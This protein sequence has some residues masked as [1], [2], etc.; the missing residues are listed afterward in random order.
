MLV[1]LKEYAQIVGVSYSSARHAVSRG[2]LIPECKQGRFWMVDDKTPWPGRKDNDFPGKSYTRIYRIWQGMKKRCYNPNFVS[3]NRY[4]GRGITVCEEWRNSS[5]SFYRWAINNGYSDDLS[6]DRI[7][8]D[9]NYEPS[10]CRWTTSK[11]QASNQSRSGPSTRRLNKRIEG[12]LQA[13]EWFPNDAQEYID[14]LEELGYHFD[15]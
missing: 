13:I 14:K 5:S 8:N 15:Q 11:V 10:N 2:K 7:D 12:L 6:I 9:G 4:G 3:Y 1:N